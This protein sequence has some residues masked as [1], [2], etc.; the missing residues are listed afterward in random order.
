MF[1]YF[2]ASIL[3]MVQI[4]TMITIGRK[5][6]IEIEPFM[7]EKVF[8]SLH[9]IVSNLIR[10]SMNIQELILDISYSK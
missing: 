6:P 4:S 9:I 3:K 2:P 10:L 8:E 1:S 5:L 7:L